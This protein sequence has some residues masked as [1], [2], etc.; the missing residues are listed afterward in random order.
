MSNLTHLYI[1]CTLLFAVSSSSWKC[2]FFEM[3]SFTPWDNKTLVYN[4][5]LSTLCNYFLM[6]YLNNI[7]ICSF[8]TCNSSY[9]RHRMQT[10]KVFNKKVESFTKRM[11]WNAHFSLKV[12]KAKTK[13]LFRFHSAVSKAKQLIS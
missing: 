2:G 8:K 12:K 10:I 7:N 5:H 6:T 11:R 3:I 4:F 9:C 13:H 1:G